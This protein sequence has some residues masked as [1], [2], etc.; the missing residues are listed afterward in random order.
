[1]ATTF[2]G[3]DLLSLARPRPGRITAR[4][5][6]ATTLNWPI[7]AVFLSGGT[8]L[9]QATR[10]PLADLGHGLPDFWWRTRFWSAQADFTGPPALRRTAQNFAFFFLLP[11]P[12]FIIFLSLEIFLSLGVFSWNFGGVF[13]GWDPQMCT[14]GL[15]KPRRLG[16]AG[17]TE[18]RHR[19][20]LGTALAERADPRLEPGKSVELWPQQHGVQHRQRGHMVLPLYP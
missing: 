2:F 6:L 3:H 5:I 20:N 4:L 8:D 18:R 11:L 17:V 15:L 19:N 7:W 9:G 14:L 1:M 12:I 16:A 13:E 10:V